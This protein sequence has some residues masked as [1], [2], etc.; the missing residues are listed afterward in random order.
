MKDISLKHEKIWLMVKRIPK[1][2]V[3]TYGDIAR[4]AGY[5]GCARMVGAALRAAPVSL[6]LPW[7]RVINAQG[8]ISFPAKEEKSL[9]QKELLEAEG[10]VFLSGKVSLKQ[11]AWMGNLDRELWQM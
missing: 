9:M 1:G 6:S 11:Y 3:S 8:K 5:P 4:F 2:S 10:V 7:Y